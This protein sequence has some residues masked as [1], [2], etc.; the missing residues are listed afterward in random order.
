MMNVP[1]LEKLLAEVIPGEWRAE[2]NRPSWGWAEVCIGDFRIG[3]P[4]RAIGL[5]QRDEAMRSALARLISMSPDLAR[6]VIAAEKLADEVRRISFSDN[7]IALS[8]ALAAYE[9]TK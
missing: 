1:D 2:F 4:T 6:K 9:A 5:D 3:W 7:G 8:S